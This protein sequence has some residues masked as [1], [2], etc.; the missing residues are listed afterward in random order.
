MDL[1]NKYARNAFWDLKDNNCNNYSRKKRY[2][3]LYEVSNLIKIRKKFAICQLQSFVKSVDLSGNDAVP[4]KEYEHLQG[5]WGGSAGFDRTEKRDE[6]V[7]RIANRI[8]KIPDP[9]KNVR[10]FR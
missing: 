8:R 7:S 5:Y 6:F 10:S 9:N 4:A 1:N 3:N 2:L